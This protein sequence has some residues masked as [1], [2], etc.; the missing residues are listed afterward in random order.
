MSATG[1]KR[2]SRKARRRRGAHAVQSAR[3]VPRQQPAPAR[4]VASRQE[5]PQSIFAGLPIS[6]LAILVGI[7]GLIVGWLEHN[8]TALIAGASACGVGVLE[9]TAREHFT[10]FRSHTTLLAAVPALAVVT[11]VAVLT[12]IPRDRILVLAPGVPVFLL[13]VTFL[14]RS[15]ELARHQRRI[16]QAGS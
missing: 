3:P 6:E 15:F 1:S 11:L 8:N 4:S 13:C 9:V 12:G 5:R 10:G 16:G 2:R 14:R 7:I